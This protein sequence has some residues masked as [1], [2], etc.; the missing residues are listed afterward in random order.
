MLGFKGLF[1]ASRHA[2]NLFKSQTNFGLHTVPKYHFTCSTLALNSL[3]NM[4]INPNTL[5]IA[6]L[7]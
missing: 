3:Q 1:S 6:N 7:R 2:S 4:I 5:S